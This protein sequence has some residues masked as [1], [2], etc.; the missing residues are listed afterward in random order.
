MPEHSMPDH[1]MPSQPC[2]LIIDDDAVFI[3]V[4]ARA[5]RRRGYNVLAAQNNQQA[6]Q[7][8][9]VQPPHFAVVDLKIAVESGLDCIQPLLQINADMRILILTGYASVATAV[10]AIKAGAYDYACKPLDADEILQKLAIGNDVVARPSADLAT[11]VSV[12]RLA[13]EHIQ[14]MLQENAGNISA[15]ARSLGMHRRTLQRILQKRPTS[16]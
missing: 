2:I 7:L 9:Q 8:A 11:P 10:T 4:L 1:S 15:T 16:K 12:K 6:L 14:R 5:F 3:E 13:W